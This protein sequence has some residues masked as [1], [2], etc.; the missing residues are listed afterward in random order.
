MALLKISSWRARAICMSEESR[1]QSL[2]E[3]SMS[4]KRKVTVP[5]GGL[6][7]SLEV[8]LASLERKL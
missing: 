1:S 2:V 3:P 7:T 5:V 8:L 4:V 6:A